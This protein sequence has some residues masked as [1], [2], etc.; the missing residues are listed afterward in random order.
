VQALQHPWFR[1]DV[2]P[3]AVDPGT[4]PVELARPKPDPEAE[5]PAGKGRRRASLLAGVTASP[6][7]PVIAARVQPI[8]KLPSDDG[9]PAF[10][11][12]FEGI[13]T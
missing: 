3:L 2:T 12:I 8:K 4:T 7:V 9:T 10:D 1:G 6:P 11:D 13:D 5:K